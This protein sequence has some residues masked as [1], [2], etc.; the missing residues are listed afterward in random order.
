ML[1]VNPAVK[2]C[3][4]LKP[5]IQTSSGISVVGGYQALDPVSINTSCRIEPK[6]AFLNL[7]SSYDLS[8]VEPLLEASA[9]H[10]TKASTFRNAI[11]NHEAFGEVDAASILAL[12]EKRRAYTYIDDLQI[13]LDTGGD[14]DLVT[15]IEQRRSG[16]LQRNRRQGDPIAGCCPRNEVVG[17]EVS[18]DQ[19]NANEC[20]NELEPAPREPS[21]HSR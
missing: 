5:E 17:D 12:R 6:I 16:D 19:R 8:E 2:I 10:P 11:A 14:H 13:A 1:S 15:R 9:I 20:R 4:E 3:S 21:P 18:S 7:R